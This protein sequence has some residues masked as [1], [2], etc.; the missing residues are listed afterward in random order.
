MSALVDA[1]LNQTSDLIN[2][3]FGDE[4]KNKAALR[5]KITEN[6]KL[7][8]LAGDDVSAKVKEFEDQMSRIK[9]RP[10]ESKIEGH[11]KSPRLSSLK[12]SPGPISIQRSGEIMSKSSPPKKSFVSPKSPTV[13]TKYPLNHYI[14]DL[15]KKY[16]RDINN[17][18][19]E[20]LART[21]PFKTWLR[22][23]GY[24]ALLSESMALE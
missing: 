13:S 11:M 8:K 2:E 4:T 18:N 9:K 5:E 23:H 15:Q 20:K 14:L 24:N 12:K 17:L 10:L 21:I 3:Y 19:Q 22:K 16:S 7:L 6:I 1:L